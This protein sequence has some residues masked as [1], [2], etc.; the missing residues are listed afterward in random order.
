LSEAVLAGG[1]ATKGSADTPLA[2]RL[3][4]KSNAEASIFMGVLAEGEKRHDDRTCRG[5]KE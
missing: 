1:A 3:P 5:R 2:A 4:A